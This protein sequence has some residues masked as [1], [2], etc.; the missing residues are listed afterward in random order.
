MTKQ[1]NEE[2]LVYIGT[3]TSG[4][5]EGIYVYRMDKSSGTLEFSSKATGVDN[6]SFL[7][8]HPQQRYLYAVNEIGEFA[9]KPSGAVSAF[10]IEEKTGELTYLNQQPSHGTSPCHLSVDK[11]GQFVLVANYGGGSV[12]VLPIQDDG[13]LGEAIDFIQ[14]QGS[15]INPQ[16]QEGPHAHSITLDAAN[17]YAFAAD[18]GLDKIMIYQLDLTQG[19]LKPNDEPWA[20]VKA[21]AGPRHFDF[22]PNGKYAYLINELDNT[23]IAFTYDETR[24]TLREIQT[25][26][27]LPEDFE[28]TSHTADVHV[29]PSEKFVYGSNRGHDSIVIYAIDEDTGKLTYVGHELT[30]GKSPRNFVIDPTGTFLLAANH[31]TDNIVTFRID[32][33]TGRLMPT[34]HVTEVPT[35]VCLKIIHISS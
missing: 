13:Q 2:I 14:H 3:Y 31:G 21:G 15:S 5:S 26:P 28:G 10:S 12:C 30:Q 16:R 24:G 34:G 27:T 11:T 25:V 19:K 9:G 4:K 7:A 8:I 29:S 22:H 33:Q 6:P 35:A 20:Q 1:N 18:L 17:R 32:Q 23:L